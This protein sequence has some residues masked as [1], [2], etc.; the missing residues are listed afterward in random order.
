MT[1]VLGEGSIFIIQLP[2]LFDALKSQED[3]SI[4]VLNIGLTAIVIDDDVNL[5]NLTSEVLKQNNYNALPFNNAA[6][7]LHA[8]KKTSFDFVITDIQM[9]E[10][11]GFSFLEKLQSATDSQYSNQP[12]IAVTGRAD[13]DSVFY[14]MAGFTHVLRKPYSPSQ[15]LETITLI[16]TNGVLPAHVD[17]VHETIPDSSKT[18]SLVS[19]RSFVSNEDNALKELLILFKESTVE[20]LKVLEEGIAEKND[21]KIKEIAHRMVTMFK[22]IEAHEIHKIINEFEYKDTSQEEMVSSF[23]LLKQKISSLFILLEEEMY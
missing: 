3:A 23:E 21:L 16:F 13:L 18:Y 17:P 2:L 9:P 22:Q 4:Q 20:N 1:S 11:D 5:L 8:I 12:I 6:E 14:T 15:L 19:L 7:A 10:I